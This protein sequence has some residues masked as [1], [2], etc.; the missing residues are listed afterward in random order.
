MDASLRP[1][2]SAIVAEIREGLASA[3]SARERALPGCRSVIR[4]C[5]S[6][7]RAVHRLDVEGAGRHLAEAEAALRE[8]QAILA[9]FP[10]LA[11]AGFLHDAEKEYVEAC[12]TAAMVAGQPLAGPAALGVDSRSWMKGLVEAASELRRHL[13]DRMREGDLARGEALL[14]VMDAVYDALIVV[15]YPDAITSG[16]RRSLD[17]LRA[18]LERSR[19]DVTTTVIQERLRLA[20]Q[21]SA[22][23]SA[24]PAG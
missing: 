4:S 18:V 14:A 11:W 13:L 19:G 2:L 5:G 12:L 9:P 24:P 21:G 16:L 3:N 6:S 1:E 7:I 23:R 10:D 20:L 17:A 22:D 15:D 8:V